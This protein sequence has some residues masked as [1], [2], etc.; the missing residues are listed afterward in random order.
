LFLYEDK[1]SFNVESRIEVVLSKF[2][3]RWL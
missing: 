3:I 2:C 1:V